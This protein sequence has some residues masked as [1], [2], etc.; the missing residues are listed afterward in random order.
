M[1]YQLKPRV[2][3]A[4]PMTKEEYC[5]KRGWLVPFDEDAAEI[6]MYVT[7]TTYVGVDRMSWVSM[8]VFEEVYVEAK[9]STVVSQLTDE[10]TTLAGNLN[11]L[12]MFLDKQQSLVDGGNTPTVDRQS[13]SELFLEQTLMRELLQVKSGRLSRMAISNNPL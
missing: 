8:E 6:G 2:V 1:K 11:K 10:V 5:N 9:E 12:T 4:V 13:L 7:F 3:D